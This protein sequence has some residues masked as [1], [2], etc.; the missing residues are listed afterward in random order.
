MTL[1]KRSTQALWLSS[2]LTIV[3]AL[4]SLAHAGT[5]TVYRWRTADG[6]IGFADSL[7]RVPAEYRDQAKTQTVGTLRDYAKLTVE[8]SA[9]R[10]KHS[11]AV[12]ARLESL[13]ETNR[14][15]DHVLTRAKSPEGI[16]II[17]RTNGQSSAIEIPADSYATESAEPIVI[18]SIR[19][20]DPESRMTR[21][22]T[23]Y[24]RGDQI[25]AIRRP[26]SP[27]INGR[28]FLP[29]ESDAATLTR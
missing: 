21:T 4:S 12:A 17:T 23:I 16:A 2:I 24:R 10:T 13:R 25:I 26:E 20:Y 5:A 1:K 8:D 18:E 6:T 27:L 28:T 11:E 9:T 15:L 19:M 7:K 14:V 22:N 29:V 3:F